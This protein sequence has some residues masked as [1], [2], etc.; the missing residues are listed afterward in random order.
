M[1]TL[2]LLVSVATRACQ[3]LQPVANVPNV[4]AFLLKKFFVQPLYRVS[5]L[6]KHI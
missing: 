4:P 3:N 1:A 6:P 2:E 5:L